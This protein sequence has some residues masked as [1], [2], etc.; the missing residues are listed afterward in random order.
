VGQSAAQ[1][2]SIEHNSEHKQFVRSSVGLAAASPTLGW[3]SK[4]K[5]RDILA[6][7]LKK[8]ARKYALLERNPMEV[9]EL[10]ADAR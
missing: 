8:A 6:S 5:I 3:E 9:I 4:D 7:I 10:E 2:L 1:S